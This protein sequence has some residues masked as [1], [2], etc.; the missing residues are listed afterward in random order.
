MSS[1]TTVLI[2]GANRGIGLAMVQSLL[3]N[4]PTKPLHIIACARKI[5]DPSPVPHKTEST[6]LVW[7]TLDI[8]K[9]DSISQLA[10]D[11]KVQH[12]QGINIL[13]NNAGINVDINAPAAKKVEHAEKT[14]NV[15]YSG[16]IDMMKAILPLLKANPV[17]EAEPR[18]VNVASVGGKLT[19]GPYSPDIVARY[20]NAAGIKSLDQLKDDYLQ[21]VKAE[22]EQVNGWPVGKNYAVSKSLVCAATQIMASEHRSVLINS[23][24]PGWCDSDMGGLIGKPTK[25]TAEGAKI[26]LKLAFSDIHHISGSYWENMTIS[27]EGD[28]NTSEWCNL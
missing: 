20:K 1:I 21:S 12:P 11:L 9:T 15:N 10:A 19:S 13:I 26:P 4:P 22:C 17:S 25:T 3:T 24:C 14:L 28:G 6:T 23:C 27:D 18:I 8:S 7:H 16:T 2:T 5:P